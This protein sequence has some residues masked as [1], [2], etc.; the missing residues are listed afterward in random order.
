MISARLDN[1]IRAAPPSLKVVLRGFAAL[2]GVSF[3]TK[4]P[5]KPPIL[6]LESNSA[7]PLH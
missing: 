7:H 5:G 6:A 1:G 4:E 2:A 3:R